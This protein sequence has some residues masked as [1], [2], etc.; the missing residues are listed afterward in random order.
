MSI[1][2][3]PSTDPGNSEIIVATSPPTTIVKAD[4]WSGKLWLKACWRVHVPN[5]YDSV[6]CQLGRYLFVRAVVSL[7]RYSRHV[8]FFFLF[9]E[10]VS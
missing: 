2:S 7:D 8:G 3:L 1:V 4:D 6:S 5:V 9:L 10:V